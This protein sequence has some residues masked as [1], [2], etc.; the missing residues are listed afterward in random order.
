MF[1]D[2]LLTLQRCITPRDV[3]FI[4][5]PVGVHD[6]PGRTV[7]HKAIVT[8]YFDVIGHDVSLN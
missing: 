8:G 2:L 5:S 4:V 3:G 7:T 6:G 1:I